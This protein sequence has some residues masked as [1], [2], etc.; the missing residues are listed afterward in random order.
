MAI[1]EKGQGVNVGETEI[2]DNQVAIKI[3]STDAKDYITADTTDGSE[4]IT[5]G[6]QTKIIGPGGTTGDAVP[7]GAGAPSL[8]IESS[9]GASSN[10]CTIMMNADGGNGSQIDMYVEN[11]RKML[12]MA[13]ASEQVILAED[14][15]V[16]KGES[17]D[18]TRVTVG[19]SEL[20]I[21]D[22]DANVITNNA[23]DATAKSLIFTR[24]R[25]GTDGTA[26]VVQDDDILGN[27]EFKGAEDGDSWATGAKIYA[28]VNG[29]PGDGDMPTELVFETTPDGTETPVARLSLS[30]NGIVATTTDTASCM[31]F[32]RTSSSDK[33]EIRSSAGT[34]LNIL[35]TES[36]R[37]TQSY[38]QVAELDGQTLEVK[39]ENYAASG[40]SG[41]LWT[42]LSDT[43]ANSSGTGN[44][45]IAATD[46]DLVVGQAVAL[47]SGNSNIYEF[48][49]LQP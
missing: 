11:D 14:S 8:Y 38:K 20:G 10:R 2:P 7:T 17:G 45:D 40:T 34:E 25:S 35:G 18:K 36:L 13:T 49:Q 44:R 3:S 12:I 1:V 33:L 22:L 24:S 43:T 29:T 15:L 6:Q 26:V 30:H 9:T 21:Q 27:I 16:L 37:F 32:G 4:R 23:S 31:T 19:A 41:G 47:P 39:S 48:S 46:H 28:R 42:D 5:L